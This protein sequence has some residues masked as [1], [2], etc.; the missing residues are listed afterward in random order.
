MNNIFLIFI[1]F[2]VL[3][4]SCKRKEEI[5][6]DIDVNAPLVKTSLSISDILNENIIENP[7]SSITLV[8]NYNLNTIN[9]DSLFKIPDTTVKAS[10]TIPFG[11]SITLN[12]GFQ[13]VNDPSSNTFDYG[14]AR[15]TEMKIKSGK[16]KFK[17]INN[18]KEKTIYTYTIL[19]SDDGNGN[20][21]QK[22]IIVPEKINSTPGVLQ[23]EFNLYGYTFDMTGLAG[24]KYNTL[25]TE[26][27][28]TINP[29]G[30][31]VLVQNTDTIFIENSLTEISPE[32]IKGYLGKHDFEQ[33]LSEVNFDI[34]NRITD[35]TIDLDDV[36]IAFSTKNYVGAN[37]QLKITQLNSLNTRTSNTVSLSH[38]IINNWINL[39]RASLSG[40]IITPTVNNYLLNRSNSN[41]DLF[42]ENL[43]N[44]LQYAFEAK[45]NP[46]GNVS[47]G[48]DFLYAKNT[49]DINFDISIPLNLMANNL[50]LIDTINFN[51][52]PEN[53]PI[54]SSLFTLIAN[55]GFPFDAPIQIY[56]LDNNNNISDSLFTNSLILSAQTDINNYVTNST[57]TKLESVVPE[58]KMQL[59]NTNPKM[60]IKAIFNTNSITNVKIYN[61]YKLDLT[62]VA[63]MNYTVSIK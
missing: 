3:F 16:I 61:H 62:L 8:Y 26:I 51:V 21:F 1:S 2:F 18:V 17:V 5:T 63:D 39:N 49:I 34:F 46:L 38:A 47:A 35:G 41:I 24:N 44:K 56:I 40:D 15:I 54:N 10:Y 52:N 22:E 45:L 11:S 42:I 32:Y 59:I 58:E 29:N 43:P 48:N 20:T 6:W 60:I 19:N 25:E 37:A 36:N 7:D 33:S 23:G 31:P 30:N 4:S 12:P 55:N 14:E 9:T 57:Q 50:T 53:N 28:V 13:L 27:N